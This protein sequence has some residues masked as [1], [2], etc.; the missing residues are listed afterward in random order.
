[1]GFRFRKRIKILPGV[2]LNLSKSGHSWSLGGRGATMNVSKR[3][4][5]ETYSLPGTRPRRLK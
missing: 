1:M 2:H 4:I 3:G 5:R